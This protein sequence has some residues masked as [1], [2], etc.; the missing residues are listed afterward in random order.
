[1]RKQGADSHNLLPPHIPDDQSCFVTKTFL[2]R[3]C[4]EEIQINDV[5]LFRAEI[6]VE[7]DYLITDFYL[8]CD[9]FFCDLSTLGGPTGWRHNCKNYES[10]AVFKSVQTQSFRI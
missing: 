2:V 1:M 7:P 9:L 5:V 8:D 6:D 4:E 10:K 3:Y